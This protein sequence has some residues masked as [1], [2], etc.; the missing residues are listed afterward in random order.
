MK[1][2]TLF[3]VGLSS[4]MLC[5]SAVANAQ[6]VLPAPNIA[7]AIVVDGNIDDWSAVRGVTVPLAGQGGVNAVEMKAAVRDGRIYVLAVW[8]DSTEN[9]LHKPFKWDETSSAY[10]KDAA[11][12]DRFAI[13][14]KM[15]G[16]ISMNKIGGSEFEADVWHWK[17]SRSNPA[18]IVHDK[19]WKISKKPFDKAKEWPTP[20]G[21]VVYL[22]RPSD[23]GDRLYKPLK[24]NEKQG[25]VMPRYEVN[26]TPSGSI[27]DVEAKGVW[28]DGRWHLEMSRKLDTGHDDDA[29][30]PASGSVEIA[31][32]AFNNVYSGKHSVS[33]VVVLQTGG[34]GL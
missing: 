9:I 13:S 34:F 25:E 23:A 14:L 17:A 16:D 27:A 26:L 12:E 30:I 5:F 19:M 2:T 31:I 3:R 7:E 1:K 29:V 10:K 15:S 22:A 8:A 18:G 20:D 28:R 11:K 4:A 24:Y 33:E 21:K 32:A 6:Q